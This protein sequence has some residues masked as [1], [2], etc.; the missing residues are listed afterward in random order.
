MNWINIIHFVTSTS[1]G[2]PVQRHPLASLQGTILPHT[3]QHL[4]F[5]GPVALEGPVERGTKEPGPSAH[6]QGE[7]YVQQAGWNSFKLLWKI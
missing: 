2:H 6:R 7:V 1:Q 5:R 4:P 3:P